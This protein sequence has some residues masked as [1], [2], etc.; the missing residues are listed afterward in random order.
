MNT[1]TMELNMDEMEMVNG[2]SLKEILVRIGYTAH[3]KGKSWDCGIPL[4]YTAG[5][6][7]GLCKGIY[8]EIAEEGLAS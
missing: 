5:A 3:S 6:I 7:A 1:N 4:A 2:G 8:N